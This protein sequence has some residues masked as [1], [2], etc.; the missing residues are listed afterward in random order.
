VVS[1]PM[2][3]QHRQRREAGPWAK[4]LVVFVAFFAACVMRVEGGPRV[5]LVIGVDNYDAEEVV[6]LDGAIRD[7]RIMSD[8]LRNLNPPFE[9]Q[10]LEDASLDESMD[11]MEVFLSTAR[12]AD[13]ALFFFAGHG[14]EYH[15]ENFLLTSDAR[16]EGN[17]ETSVD[18]TKRRLRR[19][20]LSLNAVMD[21]M[22]LTESDLKLIILDACR[23]NPIPPVTTRGGKTRSLGSTRGLARVS[24]PLGM[25]VS[26]SADAGEV[27]NDGLFTEILSENMHRP[28]VSVMEVFARTREKVNEISRTE[29]DDGPLYFP[30]VPAEYSKLGVAGIRFVF[31][32]QGTVE[33]MVPA[34]PREEEGSNAPRS[35]DF[36]NE[37]GIRMIHVPAGEFM[38]GDSSGDGSADELPLRSVELSA[39][40]L[41]AIEITWGQWREVMGNSPADLRKEA[42]YSGSVPWDF[43]DD[44]P[45]SYVSWEDAVE[46][47]QRL[48]ALERERS[49]LPREWSYRLPTEAQWEYA[50]RAGSRGSFH[51][52][53]NASGEFGMTGGPVATGTY[54]A[55]PFGLFDMHGNVW[56]WCQ[57]FHQEGYQGMAT[58]DPAG[59]ASGEARVFRGGSWMDGAF[60]A[61]ASSRGYGLPTLRHPAVGFR[62]AL[63]REE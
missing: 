37:T 56:E 26:Y 7:A 24:A 41:G 63:V 62:V 43:G 23:N 8:T 2:T 30:Q 57:D 61:R 15:G 19:K 27:A 35:V 53:P 44:R 11:A 45:A 50:C 20:M 14:I 9:V 1:E 33:P 32:A 55:N 5:A 42:G 4:R 17:I 25:L 52:D 40:H 34:K 28:G 59:P 13:C 39:F 49:N 29:G 18:A 10:L 31:H 58:R 12:R 36:A 51:G 46:F 54:E 3:G 60:A 22:E 6:D 21:D 38:M 47:C 16:I 48:T